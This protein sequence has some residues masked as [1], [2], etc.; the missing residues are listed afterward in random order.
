MDGIRDE[1]YVDGPRWQLRSSID[2]RF[3]HTSGGWLLAIAF[4]VVDDFG[5]IVP[6]YQRP[7]E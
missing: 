4:G 3:W 7:L 6:S 1:H 2:R 5:N